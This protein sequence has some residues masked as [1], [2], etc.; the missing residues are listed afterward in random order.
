M[1]N[2]FAKSLAK[3]VLSHHT[4]RYVWPRLDRN[5]MSPICIFSLMANCDKLKWVSFCQLMYLGTSLITSCFIRILVNHRFVFRKHETSMWRWSSRI[6]VQREC[7]SITPKLL[8]TWT[9]SAA[10]V[11]P[12]DLNYLQHTNKHTS[13]KYTFKANVSAKQN[14]SCCWK[15]CVVEDRRRQII[16]HIHCILD[17]HTN[18]MSYTQIYSQ[19]RFSHALH[20][21]TCIT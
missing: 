2:C 13:A 11:S 18:W 9:L 16:F 20:T 4:H 5:E 12:Y 3:Y 17:A 8:C 14:R 7:S 1:T 10:A 19:R 15:K 21:W 6:F